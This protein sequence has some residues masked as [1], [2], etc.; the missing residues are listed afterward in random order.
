VSIARGIQRSEE[1]GGCCQ[2]SKKLNDEDYG[3]GTYHFGGSLII[4]GS[5][6]E[7][8]GLDV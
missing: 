4:E 5:P 6:G 1:E 8:C 3:S 2:E 7:Y